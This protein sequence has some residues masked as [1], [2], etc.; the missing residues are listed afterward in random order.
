MVS[1]DDIMNFMKKEKEDRAKERESDKE[2]IKDMI[3]NGVKEEVEK[4][5]NPG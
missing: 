2:E 3:L 1:L 4:N 5:I